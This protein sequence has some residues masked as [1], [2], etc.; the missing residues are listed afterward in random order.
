MLVCGFLCLTQDLLIVF[1]LYLALNLHLFFLFLFLLE[2]V[3]LDTS[4]LVNEEEG[5]LVACIPDICQFFLHN[6][7][8]RP[9]NFTLE[10]AENVP[11]EKKA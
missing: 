4:A 9:G 7:N 5:I 6:R 2:I 1:F 8:L 10:S 11:R 3:L